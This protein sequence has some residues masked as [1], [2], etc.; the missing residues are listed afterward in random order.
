MENPVA[1]SVPLD[2]A[3]VNQPTTLDDISQVKEDGCKEAELK[4]LSDVATPKK[5]KKKTSYKAMLEGMMTGS[6]T[7]TDIEKQKDKIR[8]V[9]GGGVFVK[10]DKI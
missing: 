6:G 4:S 8:S 2:V 7:S 10:I 5:K 9:T 3:N 1:V